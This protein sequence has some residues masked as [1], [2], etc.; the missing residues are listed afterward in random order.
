M[1]D[2]GSHLSALAQVEQLYGIEL[3]ISPMPLTHDEARMYYFTLSDKWR[4]PTTVD[5]DRFYELDVYYNIWIDGDPVQLALSVTRPHIKRMLVLIKR[6]D[7][8]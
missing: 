3:Y 4:M 7:N 2:D 5:I 8:Q 6:V 1:S